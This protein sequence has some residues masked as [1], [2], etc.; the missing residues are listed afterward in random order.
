MAKQ[1]QQPPKRRHHHHDRNRPER[2]QPPQNPQND[3]ELEP[4]QPGAESTATALAP[5][6]VGDGGGGGGPRNDD[7]SAIDAETNAKYEQVKGGKLYIKD[8]QQM[9]IHALHEIAKE[10]NLQD[11]IGMK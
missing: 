2:P 9:D 8:L 7:V 3:P 10:E 6:P 5:P 1:G 4:Q 11:Y